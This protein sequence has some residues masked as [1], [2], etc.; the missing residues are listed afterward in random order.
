MRIAQRIAN[1]P[2]L[3]N[4]LKA[5]KIYD[6]DDSINFNYLRKCGKIDKNN[7]KY[8]YTLSHENRQKILKKY[9]LSK[10][11]LEKESKILFFEFVNF[12]INN[13]DKGKKITDK[14][15]KYYN[16]EYFGKFIIQI[17]EGTEEL[18]YYYFMSII[19]G[20]LKKD[21]LKG[22][23]S[24]SYFS[25]FFEDKDNIDKIETIFYLLFRVDF[26]F[27]NSDAVNIN[28]ILN[29]Q[30]MIDED[31]EDKINMMKL[32][33]D[34]IKDNLN[35]KKIHYDTILT[36]KK[37]N[38]K[39]SLSDYYFNINMKKKLH[40]VNC[41]SNKIS[42]TYDYCLKDKFNYFD[43]DNEANAFFIIFKKILSSRVMKEYYLKLKTSEKYEFPFNNAKIIQFLWRK[44]IF[45]EIEDYFG[46]TNKEGFGIFI[47]RLKG[48]KENGLG[49]GLCIITIL[50]EIVTHSLTNLINSNDGIEAGSNT[51]IKIFI[52]SSDNNK[53]I[54]MKDIGE[55]FEFFLFGERVS[56]LTIGGN[57][58][59]FNINNWN[60]SL[61]QFHQGFKKNNIAKSAKTLKNELKILM[62]N[63]VNVKLLFNNVNYNGITKTIETQ[64]IPIKKSNER[65]RTKEVVA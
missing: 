28:K 41:I 6:I 62:E 37:G 12:L 65:I 21:R 43:S 53:T 49:Y 58:Y 29:I 30:S 60:L 27:F 22:L 4:L 32:I 52:K 26:F 35:I 42:M 15:L 20:W 24:L 46:L 8:I 63:D 51:P 11:S 2:T 59:I 1:K 48:N 50:H 61:N 45:A 36:L 23:T 16:L 13:Y 44:I 5:I 17:N 64:S 10:E 54:K 47:N 57:H 38:Y 39:F 7:F 9:K 34:E 33:K 18:K 19:L 56:Q 55:K 14:Q 40:V 25:K 3:A 31:L